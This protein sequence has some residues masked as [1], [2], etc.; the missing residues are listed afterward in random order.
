MTTAPPSRNPDVGTPTIVTVAII[1][2]MREAHTGS[3]Y[4]R[5]PR[6]PP[7]PV[8]LPGSPGAPMFPSMLP[9]ASCGCMMGA[10]PRAMTKKGGRA[11]MKWTLIMAEPRHWGTTRDGKANTR[12]SNRAPET[13]YR[14]SNY[15][16]DKG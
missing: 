14:E 10:N 5:R 4:A 6:D 3:E 8:R 12:M 1:K 2:G 11:Q 15:R 16:R 9:R 13:V 7:V